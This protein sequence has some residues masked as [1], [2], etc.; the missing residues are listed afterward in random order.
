MDTIPT[1]PPPTTVNGKKKPG[2]IVPAGLTLAL[3]FM[4]GDFVPLSFRPLDYLGMPYPRI[5]T[6]MH[7]IA[8]VTALIVWIVF[9]RSTVVAIIAF[10]L[11]LMSMTSVK[12]W[13][14]SQPIKIPITHWIDSYEFDAWQKK[15]GFKV[16]ERG[17]SQG[18]WLW[19]DRTPGRADQV[20]DELKEMGK[21]RQ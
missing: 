10:C 19:V 11:A 8:P 4:G 16:W 21:K 18:N 17:D 3:I 14:D 1:T 12:Q 2:I 20:R 15:I 6:Y 9:K 5:L 13:A 7:F